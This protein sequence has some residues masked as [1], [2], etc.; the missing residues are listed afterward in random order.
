LTIA[1]KS[2]REEP[3]GGFARRA[4]GLERIGPSGANTLPNREP[5]APFDPFGPFALFARLDAL[6]RRG[7]FPRGSPSRV[8]RRDFFGAASSSTAGIAAVSVVSAAPPDFA[9]GFSFAA[10]CFDFFSVRSTRARSRAAAVRAGFFAEPLGDLG[11]CGCSSV[12]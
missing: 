5:L 1:M 12:D 2:G 7:R 9:L 11:T 6:A 3:R 4:A 10:D 8:G